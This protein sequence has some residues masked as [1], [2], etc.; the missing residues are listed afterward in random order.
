MSE[1][2]AVKSTNAGEYGDCTGVL[3]AA[4]VV[5]ASVLGV[6]LL[7]T[8]GGNPLDQSSRGA[9][10]ATCMALGFQSG[11]LCMIIVEYESAGKRRCRIN[12]SRSRSSRLDGYV[13]V[14]L[15]V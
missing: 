11:L 3:P 6:M 13:C 10:V 5:G 7:C 12:A 15:V 14:A 2:S 1:L 4:G 8:I 9:V